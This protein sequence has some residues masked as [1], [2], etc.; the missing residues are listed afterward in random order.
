MTNST[1]A[2]TTCSESES[3]SLTIEL[4]AKN[5]EWMLSTFNEKVFKL[6]DLLLVI[7]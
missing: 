4:A 7:M 5:L 3:N 1:D 2:N 6:E